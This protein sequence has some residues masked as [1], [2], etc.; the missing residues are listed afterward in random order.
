[1][2]PIDRRYIEYAI[3]AFLEGLRNTVNNSMTI[4]GVP[5]EIQT[6]RLLSTALDNYLYTNQLS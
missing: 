6:E 3:L 4:V 2:Q 5:A 1:V